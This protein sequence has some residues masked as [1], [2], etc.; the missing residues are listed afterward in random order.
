V[1]P[2]TQQTRFVG[3]N[4]LTSE[5][6]GLWFNH[7]ASLEEGPCQDPPPTLWRGGCCGGKVWALPLPLSAGLDEI[8]W[9]LGNVKCMD[10]TSGRDSWPSCA[11]CGSASA[12]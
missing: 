7:P 11:H 1:V 12:A 10:F 5:S 2:N 4:V 8:L 6:W 9:T 3:V